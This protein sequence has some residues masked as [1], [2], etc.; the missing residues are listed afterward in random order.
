MVVGPLRIR[1]FEVVFFLYL[2]LIL[3][4]AATQR[5]FFSFF[6]KKHYRLTLDGSVS[7]YIMLRN[8]KRT[9]QNKGDTP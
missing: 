3:G 1:L 6:Q 4:E 5:I 9:K 2:N 8:I 7:C